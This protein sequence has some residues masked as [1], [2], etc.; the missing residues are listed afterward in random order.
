MQNRGML[1]EVDVTYFSE[2]EKKHLEQVMQETNVQKYK[3]I[4][5]QEFEFIVK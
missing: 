2:K 3:I 4:K 1:N 5:S